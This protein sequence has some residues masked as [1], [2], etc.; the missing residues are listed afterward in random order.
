MKSYPLERKKSTEKNQRI[1]AEYSGFMFL[2]AVA[3]ISFAIYLILKVW[4]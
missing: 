1:E 4:D 2:L 3:K